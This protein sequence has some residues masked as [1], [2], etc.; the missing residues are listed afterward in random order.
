MVPR[1]RCITWLEMSKRYELCGYS[2]TRACHFWIDCVSKRFDH[3]DVPLLLA[4][5]I[6]FVLFCFVVSRAVNCK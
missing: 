4:V 6:I 1:T 2:D 3:I 5:L